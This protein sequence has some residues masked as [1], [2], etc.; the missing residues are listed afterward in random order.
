MTWCCGADRRICNPEDAD[1]GR[2]LNDSIGVTRSANAPGPTPKLLGPEMAASKKKSF[3]NGS[4]RE[5]SSRSEGIRLTWSRCCSTHLRGRSD[6]SCRRQSLAQTATQ[7]SHPPQRSLQILPARSAQRPLPSQETQ[8]KPDKSFALSVPYPVSIQ[9]THASILA[10]RATEDV[11]S[12]FRR[13]A[14][15]RRENPRAFR[16]PRSRNR[17]SL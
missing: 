3:L 1:K 7:T 10:A 8:S 15:R 11:G 6:R 9:R 14:R 17:K 2:I 12:Q 13:C 5:R 4:P 16:T